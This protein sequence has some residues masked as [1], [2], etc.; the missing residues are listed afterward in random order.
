[1]TLNFTEYIFLIQL[2]SYTWLR[3]FAVH[4]RS[5]AICMRLYVTEV[6]RQQVFDALQNLVHPGVRASLKMISSRY[7]WPCINMDVQ[8]WKR[9]C[10]PCQRS[11]IQRQN[12]A[13][14]GDFPTPDARFQH[15]YTDSAGHL[16][17]SQSCSYLQ[18]MIDCFTR[19]PMAEPIVYIIAAT[20]M[21]S[22]VDYWHFI[23]HTG[24]PGS[25]IR[26]EPAQW[27]YRIFRCSTASNCS[28]PPPSQ[29]DC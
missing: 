18:T 9:S 28:L 11:K 27:D 16:P 7:I 23:Q 5:R 17:V 19:F 1:M 25:T 14:V 26:T 12:R 4:D 2:S 20:I 6:F 10:M 21:Q 3:W 24:K 13:P 8:Q 29:W 22:P 15:I